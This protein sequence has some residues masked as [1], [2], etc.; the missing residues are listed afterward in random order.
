MNVEE[1]IIKHFSILSFSVR[2]VFNAVWF[3]HKTSDPICFHKDV[4]INQSKLMFKQKFAPGRSWGYENGP[5]YMVVIKSVTY[6][7]LVFGHLK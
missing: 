1:K 7:N 5:W 3:G 6:L 4:V 2:S